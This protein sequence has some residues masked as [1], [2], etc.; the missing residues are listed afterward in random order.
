MVASLARAANA[1]VAPCARAFLK[2]GSVREPQ[3]GQACCRCFLPDL[4][5]F[6]SWTSAAPD[7]AE[8]GVSDNLCKPESKSGLEAKCANLKIGVVEKAGI[9]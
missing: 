6:A 3:H 5:G 1:D 4:A 2:R 7:S 8:I 9:R